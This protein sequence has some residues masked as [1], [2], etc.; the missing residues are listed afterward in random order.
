MTRRPSDPAGAVA[1]ER[2]AHAAA[3]AAQWRLAIPTAAVWTVTWWAVGADAD[4]VTAVGGPA[5]V[6]GLAAAL[7]CV[8]GGSRAGW[9]GRLGTGV[10]S[11]VVTSVVVTGLAVASVCLALAPR[12]VH[13]R[14]GEVARLAAAGA[15]VAVE[16]VITGD[17]RDAGDRGGVVVPAVA[18]SVTVRGTRIAVETPV[19]V[20]AGPQWATVRWDGRYVATGV[21]ATTR[22]PSDRHAA[23]L[24]PRSTPRPLADP[25]WP[26]RV[27]EHVRTR[28][29]EAAAP[30]PG[31]A[32]GL[33]PSLA[34]GDTRGVSDEL[35]D[36]MRDAG[37]AHLSAVSG[38][39]VTVVC[40]GLVALLAWAGARRRWQVLAGAAAL[41]ALVVTARPEPSVLR[42][43]VMGG[44]GLLGLL[45][46]RPGRA[47]PAICV[48]VLVLLAAD[49]WLSRSFGFALSVS[50][51]AG[52]V[53]LGRPL[54][55]RLRRWVPRPVA[56]PLAVTAAAQATVT[57]VLVL[58]DPVLTPYAVL[59]NLAVGPVVAPTMVLAT[60]SGAASA[61]WLPAGTALAAPAAV[62]AAWISA[63]AG[64][65]AGAPGSRIPWPTGPL[66]ALLAA[67]G[68]IA[69]VAVVTGLAS[70]R[71][72]QEDE[73]DRRTR[74]AFRGRALSIAAAVCAPVLVIAL[75]V[76]P[77][78]TGTTWVPGDWAVVVCDVGQG[79]AL[80]VRAG[81]RAAVVI[82]TGPEPESMARCLSDAGVRQVPLL[83]LT[84][85]HADHVGGLAAVLADEGAGRLWHGPDLAP[86][87]TRTLDAVRAASVPATRVA[88]GDEVEVG[89]LR[90]T[91]LWPERVLDPAGA[92]AGD[93]TAVNDAGL[94]IRVDGP[95]LSLIAL[96]DVETAA[97]VRLAALD[98]RLLAA[99]VT[100]IAHHGSRTQVPGL[101]GRIGPTVAVAS[102][103]RDNDYGHPAAQTLTTVAAT[104]AHVAVTAGTG[105]VAVSPEPSGPT[106][107]SR[108][109]GPTGREEA[110]VRTLRVTTR[111]R[112]GAR[113][114]GRLPGCRLPAGRRPAEA[115]PPPPGSRPSWSPL[116][117]SSS[118]PARTT[119]WPTWRCAASGKLWPTGT[120]RWSRTAST[121]PAPP[122][123]TCWRRSPRRC[124]VAPGSWSPADWRRR[125][126]RSPPTCSPWRRHGT[127]TPTPTSHWLRGTLA[128][129]GGERCSRHS[130]RSRGP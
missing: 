28:T 80:L 55:L 84:H 12:L 24:R 129:W 65:A 119:H 3:A 100:T 57:P 88:P 26:W 92:A 108:P 118:C 102:A 76:V 130:P 58:L 115:P 19:L 121:A 71:Q 36:R 68:V 6:L 69:M 61:L 97:Q 85:F 1:A 49:P 120:R 79:E 107:T 74:P 105:G 127:A 90:L 72:A 37:L 83:V 16:L 128:G 35:A 103:G 96:G 111:R 95:A 67:A 30:L 81:P 46:G 64:V 114:S 5:F 60:A 23:V 22:D 101:Y 94:V 104:G 8:A 44:V 63:V 38:A 21:L 53:V 99:D 40:G 50:A 89:G 42:A 17:P 56:D 125:R 123:G 113:G 54:A 2:A 48:A 66:G 78:R 45:V 93:G 31:P 59:A 73:P 10:A 86:G 15:A 116:P 14:E 117:P 29:R 87:A 43:A 4:A 7:G 18:E 34:L 70:G 98:P 126:A 112:P 13:I 106:G 109:V 27:A 9:T 62:G 122:P 52:I 33:L 124:S 20:V 39:N 41:V 47:P 25:A 110:T 51:T 91:A 32:P 75:Q 82:D 11:V 77:V